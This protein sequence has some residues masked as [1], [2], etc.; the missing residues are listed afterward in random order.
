MLAERGLVRAAT[1]LAGESTDEVCASLQRW[2][3]KGERELPWLAGPGLS[4][5]GRVAA[6]PRAGTELHVL[7]RFLVGAE[8]DPDRV[9]IAVAI[10]EAR[11]EPGIAL[12]PDARGALAA[13]AA[14]FFDLLGMTYAACHRAVRDGQ[15]RRVDDIV[16]QWQPQLDAA[17]EQIE[18]RAQVLTEGA[19]HTPVIPPARRV[20][21]R[22]LFAVAFVILALVGAGCVLWLVLQ[23]WPI[24]SV[25]LPF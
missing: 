5:L 20:P 6:A 13:A 12:A 21:D 23:G 24:R 1:R 18:E 9:R 2:R 17:A 8:T 10:L 7:E 3:D 22:G 15:R 11:E 4:A 14:R 19:A 25:D 16:A